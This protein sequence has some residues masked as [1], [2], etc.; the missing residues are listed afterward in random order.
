MSLRNMINTD[1]QDV[2]LNVSDF[3]ELITLHLDGNVSLKAIVDIP[4]STDT[5]DG[6]FPITGSV[7]IAAADL[8]RLRL[9][10]KTT[11]EATVR[12]ELW[13]M[14]EQSTDEFGMVRFQI[15][16]KFQEQKY[17]NRYDLQGKQIPFASE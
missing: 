7:S 6:T 13:H 3:A 15:R 1:V 8:K 14:Y 10:D 12:A 16:R 9:A 17:T 11:L 4:E 5:G 2:F